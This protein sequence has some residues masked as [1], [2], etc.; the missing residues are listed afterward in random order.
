MIKSLS[1]REARIGRAVK[2]FIGE[3]WVWVPPRR[4]VVFREDPYVCRLCGEQWPSHAPSCPLVKL[5][6]ALKREGM[7]L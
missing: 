7:E 6:E 5:Q 1:E 2:E 4:P 3:C